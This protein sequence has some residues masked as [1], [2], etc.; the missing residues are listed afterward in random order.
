[1]QLEGAGF[2]QLRHDVITGG[3]VGVDVDLLIEALA[4]RHQRGLN[5]AFIVGFCRADPNL[6]VTYS[7]CVWYVD[8]CV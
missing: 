1:M 4:H 8:V 6:E 2:E 7:L 3:G 5:P